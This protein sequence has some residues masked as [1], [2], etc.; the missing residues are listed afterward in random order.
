MGKPQALDCGIANLKD[1]VQDDLTVHSDL[2]RC[3]VRIH[4]A[5]ITSTATDSV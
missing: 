3:G 1:V 5:G 4:D 2:P